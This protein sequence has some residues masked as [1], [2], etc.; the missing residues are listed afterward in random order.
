MRL[1]AL[2]LHGAKGWPDL[3]LPA[4]SPSLNV[5]SGPAGTGKTTLAE[6]LGHV[7]YGRLPI[8][9]VVPEGEAVV[10]SSTGRLRVRRYHDG[11][12]IGRLTVASLDG[13]SV[14]AEMVRRLLGRMS[15]GLLG[16]LYAVGF[17]TE[18]QVDRLLAAKFAREFQSLIGGSVG[19]RERRTPELAERRDTLAQELEFQIARERRASG[20]LDRQ[21]R[22]LDGRMRDAEHDAAALELRLRAV[23]TALAETDARLRYR[24][25]ELNTE[26]RWHVAE[27]NEGEPQLAE[28]DEEIARWRA[29]LAELARRE[30]TVR[31]KLAQVQSGDVPAATLADQRAWMAV[32]RQ[33]AADLAGEVARLARASASQT[34]AE[35]VCRDAHPRLRPIVETLE[36]QLDGMDAL[37]TGQQRAAQAADMAGEADYLAR[38]ED[39]LRRQ[40]DY[41]LDRREA[42][43]RG[44]APGRSHLVSSEENK[45][46]G[47]HHPPRAVA[48]R[49][50]SAADAEQLEQRRVEL[51]QERFELVNRMRIQHG[52][53]RAMRVERTD[54]DRQRAALLSA[55]SI[56]HVQ[57]QLV[58]AQQEL[59]RAANA[60]PPQSE[61][62]E[63]DGDPWRASD[64]LAQ[65]TDGRLV[66]IQCTDGSGQAFAVHKTGT[67]A[68][69]ESLK[70]ADRDLV[71]LSFTL[72]LVSAAA[73]QGVRLP[74][75][76]DDPFVRLD[77]R[78]TASLAAVLDDFGRHGHQ[79]VLFTGQPTAAER[80]ASIG[81]TVRDIVGLRHWRREE[82]ESAAQAPD[83]TPGV[84]ATD[85]SVQL[86]RGKR[87][88]SSRPRKARRADKPYRRSGSTPDH[89]DAA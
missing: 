75:V 15:P 33:L 81:V 12:A 9:P 73:K 22:E 31:S 26:L 71:Y 51:E 48:P 18:P 44:V 47:G 23:E 54:V 58:T 13:Q 36:R 85:P 57:H 17:E 27:T 70:G 86:K 5:L 50:L 80:L 59:E 19:E 3:R 65:L 6:F 7:L 82:M 79:V 63:L 16:Q 89:S 29:T 76:L 60:A 8:R 39:A 67:T 61:N 64:Y 52:L 41:L 56:E 69:L 21:R 25:L 74:L 1:A 77:A 87:K 37:L 24:R 55:R 4:L 11:T 2:A 10:E 62:G 34:S 30:A 32:A 42:L 83:K 68:P 45:P 46:D 40:L 20:D 35:G 78:D 38:S 84:V 66:R 72:A 53:L 28:L 49:S 88:G 43:V 14:D